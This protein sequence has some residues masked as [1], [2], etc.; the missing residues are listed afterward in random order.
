MS[1][2][3][4]GSQ[5]A[6]NNP[7]AFHTSLSNLRSKLSQKEIQ[8]F[9]FASLDELRTAMDDIQQ[10]QV[11]RG[12]LQCLVRIQPFL[13][14]MEQYGKVVEVFLN[15]SNILAFVWVCPYSTRNV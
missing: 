15:T 6:T 10:Q 7:A 4:S 5:H 2:S 11:R 1:A 13:L 9:Q 12:S 3:G 8:D 14:A